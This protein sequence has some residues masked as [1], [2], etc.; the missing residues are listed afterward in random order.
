MPEATVHKYDH[1]SPRKDEIRASWKG[2]LMETE[3]QSRGMQIPPQS[4]FGLRVTT[5]DGAHHPRSDLWRNRV[6]QVQLLLTDFSVLEA[7]P[8]SDLVPFRRMHLRAQSVVRTDTTI[9][10]DSCN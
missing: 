10:D 2:P 9:D 7:P 6:N 1:L 3:P 4:H 5:Q 8:L